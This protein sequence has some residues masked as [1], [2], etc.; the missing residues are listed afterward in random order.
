MRCMAP[1]SD[2]QST[3]F[4]FTDMT[5]QRRPTARAGLLAGDSAHVHYPR[6]DR[7]SASVCRMP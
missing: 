3:G 2:P 1:T 6:A 4:Q 7:V 5:R